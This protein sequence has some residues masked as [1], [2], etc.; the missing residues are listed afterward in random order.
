MYEFEDLRVLVQAKS[1]LIIIETYEELRALALI[2]RLAVNLMR[3][4]F[5]WTITDGLQRTDRDSSPQAFNTEPAQLLAQIKGTRIPGIY[6]LCDFHP[7]L[8]E[9]RNIRFIKEIAQAHDSLGHTVILLSYALDTPP[10]LARLS[11]RFQLSLPGEQQIRQMINE[12]ADKY[13][14][15]HGHLAEMAPADVNA[16]VSNLHGLTFDEAKRLAYK[17]IA[18]DGAITGADIPRIN[19]AKFNML[20]TAGTLS[21][22]FDTKSLDEVVGMP[23]LKRWLKQREQ[24]FKQNGRDTP[25]GILLTGVQGTG[26]SLTTKAIAGGWAIPLLRLDMA[27]LYNKYI[28]ETEKNLNQALAQADAMAP[29]VLWIDEIEK[30]LAGG[31]NDNGVTRRIL[32]SL[33][34]WMA[35]RNKPVFLVATA[36]NIEELAPELLRKGRFDEIFFVDLPDEQQIKALLSLHL[37]RRQLSLTDAEL[38]QC[39]ALA[40]GFSG[41]ELEQAVVSA[42]YRMHSDGGG[43]SLQHL[44]AELAETQPLSVVMA[45][46]VTRLR[47]WAAERC[48]IA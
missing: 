28:G 24:A 38:S 3:P 44:L 25:K 8:T 20:Q 33:L 4:V 26:K 45:E 48:V 1:P 5:Q 21:Q 12:A 41:A 36:N 23:N 13:S 46:R 19:R 35:E 40:Q 32:G 30:G 15:E 27:A 2:K 11:Y 10:E 18:D 7:F 6:V 17:A 9:P 39:V 47:Q 37:Q 42:S 31:D 16:L 22:V 34:T 29:C 14:R 43:F